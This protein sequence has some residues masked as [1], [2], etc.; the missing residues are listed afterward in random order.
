MTSL[1]SE[2]T[3]SETL[4]F[5]KD[6]ENYLFSLIINVWVCFATLSKIGPDFNE[7]SGF[8]IEVTRKLKLLKK[9]APKFLFLNEKNQKDSDDI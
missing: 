7:K 5:Q 1:T 2:A 9:C 4:F 6:L 8:K 3:P